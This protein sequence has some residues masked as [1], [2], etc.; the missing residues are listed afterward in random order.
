MSAWSS[1]MTLGRS[2]C[3]F[4]SRP[5][6]LCLLAVAI[7]L[8]TVQ[9]DLFRRLVSVQEGRSQRQL[10]AEAGGAGGK[11]GGLGHDLVIEE[12]RFEFARGRQALLLLDL[13]VDSAIGRRQRDPD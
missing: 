13:I 11:H 10:A 7:V 4:R 6:V 1:A 8:P 9:Q 12:N 5:V 2:S 3:H